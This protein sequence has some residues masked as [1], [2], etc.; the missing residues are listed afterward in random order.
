MPFQHFLTTTLSVFCILTHLILTIPYKSWWW[1][2]LSHVQLC[3][4]M[5][6]TVHGILGSLS[7]LQG[8]FPT[9]GWNPGLPHCRRILYQLSHKGSWRILAWVAYPFSSGSSRPR[10]RTG[11]SCI[12]GRFFTNRAMREALINLILANNKADVPRAQET[13][14]AWWWW[15]WNF[16]WGSGLLNLCI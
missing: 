14:T 7:L 9:Q 5:D 12:A 6:Y 2:S 4:R 13:S 8:I 1:K 3:D 16:K 10:N 15:H 11:I